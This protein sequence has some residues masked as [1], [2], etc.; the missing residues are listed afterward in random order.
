M[1]IILA[2]FQNCGRIGNNHVSGSSVQAT[3][4]YK[5]ACYSAPGK[6]CIERW[7]YPGDAIDFETGCTSDGAAWIDRCPVNSDALGAC[8][9]QGD[10]VYASIQ[11]YSYFGYYGGISFADEQDMAAKNCELNGHRWIDIQLN[12]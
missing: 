11:T 8:F 1:A 6:F 5:G 9:M 2:C 7:Q 10:G 3:G 4:E 12:N